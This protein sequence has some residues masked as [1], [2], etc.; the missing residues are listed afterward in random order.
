MRRSYLLHDMG[1]E[2]LIICCGKFDKK[3]LEDLWWFQS[4]LMVLIIK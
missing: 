3:I 1:F 2:L 4:D